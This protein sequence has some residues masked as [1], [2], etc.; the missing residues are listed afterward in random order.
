MNN[1]FN[2]L[3][4]FILGYSSKTNASKAQTALESRLY[5]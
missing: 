5:N 1:D 2:Y 4:S 3:I